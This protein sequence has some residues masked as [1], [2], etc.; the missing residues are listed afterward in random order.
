[1]SEIRRSADR[2]AG[3][4]DGPS[5]TLAG[6]EA[7]AIGEIL[8][9]HLEPELHR[10][11]TEIG[12]EAAD[13]IRWAAA[14]IRKAGDAWANTVPHAG[15]ASGTTSAA[16]VAAVRRSRP[17]LLSTGQAAKELHV[18]PDAAKKLAQR[19]VL[20]Q[21]VGRDFVFTRTEIDA[22]LAATKD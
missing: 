14:G 1:M 10:W 3:Y 17:E 4:H 7:F 2:P 19:G 22:Y 16:T 5:Q 12:P 8:R 11:T 6:F 18:T 13:R 21:K 15:P 9:I 20:G